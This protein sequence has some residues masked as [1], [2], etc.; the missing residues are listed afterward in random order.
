MA[1]PAGRNIPLS[2]SRRFMGDLAHFASKVPSVPMHRRM[3]LAP[4]VAARVAAAPRPTWCAIF[5]KAYAIVSARR[6]ALRRAYIGFPRP[7]LYE[8]PATT[9]SVAVERHDGDEPDVFFA[10][11]FSPE[12]QSL[13]AIDGCLRR[14]REER[15]EAIPAFRLIGSTSRLPRP[16][17][18][19]LWWLRLNA[20]G[21]RRATCLGTFG[22]SAVGGLGAASLHL[23][24]PLT[25]ALS[26]G[27]IAA[28]GCVDVGLTFDQRA[29]DAGTIAR[30]LRE[31]EGVLHHE[32]VR[33]MGYLRALD[34]A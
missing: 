21:R 32:I 8:H 27:V 14:C 11:I 9:A 23:L 3:N 2:L 22:L 29:L 30:A 12:D 13:A 18:R 7:H 16:L 15:I 5:T 31:L 17:R 24:S 33:E 28:D 4:V 6:P 1:Q 20:S 19:F 10:P 26:F 34:V 25:T